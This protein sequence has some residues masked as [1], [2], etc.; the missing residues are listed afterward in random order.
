MESTYRSILPNIPGVPWWAA[1]LIAMATSAIGYAI[2][3]SN[4]NLTAVFTSFYITGCVAAVLAV[5]QSGL[6]TAVIQPP[7]ILFCTV[8]AAYWLFHDSRIDSL[9]DFLVNCGYPLIERFPLMLGTAGSVLLI[10]LVR[11]L[12][13]LICRTTTSSN[14]D[15]CTASTVGRPNSLNSGITAILDSILCIYSNDQDD[16]ANQDTADV[17]QMHSDPPLGTRQTARKDRSAQR[18]ARARSRQARRAMEDT[19]E[20]LV[21]P[22]RHSSQRWS[23]QARDFDAREPPRQSRRKPTPQSDPELRSQPPREIRRDAYGRRRSPYEWPAKQSGQLEPYRRYEQPRP[24]KHFT[25][26]E[27]LYERYK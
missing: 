23:K 10:G 3:A 8:P 7:L 6:F 17:Q 25:G 19:S 20:P 26:H 18:P 9:K 16:R 27:Q 21:E 11:W 14:S 13:G 4:T 1:M 5:R 24:P 15:D 22:R 2:D 12:F